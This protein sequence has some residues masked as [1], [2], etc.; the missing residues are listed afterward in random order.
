MSEFVVVASYRNASR[1]SD[2][3]TSFK[4]VATVAGLSRKTSGKRDCQP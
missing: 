4:S 3:L 2:V 1:Y